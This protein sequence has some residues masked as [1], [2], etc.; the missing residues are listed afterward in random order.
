MSVLQCHQLTKSFDALPVVRGIDLSI[1]QGEFVTLLGPSGCGKT[2][3][4]RLFAGF[5]TPDAGWI[6]VNG[7][8]VAGRG[9]FVQPE[10]RHIGMV[11][12]DYA[13]FPHLNVHENIAFGLKGSKGEKAARV[14]EMLELVGLLGLN[15][16]MTHELSGGQQQRVALAR[17]LAPQPNVLLLDEPFSN[18]D[19]TLRAQVRTE[20]KAILKQ[21]GTACIFVTHD[22]EEALSLSDRIAVMFAGQF[23][24]V[25]TPQTVY[26]QPATREVA[27]FVGEA[28]FV[29]GEALGTIAATALGEV[30]LADTAQ[31]GVD[32]MLRP[33]QLDLSAKGDGARAEV[34][35]QE[36]YGHGQ[37]VG[38]TLP[39]GTPLTVRADA[40]DV[41]TTG[42][43]VGVLIK[44][45]GRTYKPHPPSPSP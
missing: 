23:A 9:E 6:A 40:T 21:A 13:L 2:T 24:Q 8:T 37:R 27:A 41:Y 22:Q 43:Q 30:S 15:K 25:D 35:W 3:T 29:R 26:R 44:G 20:V 17:A 16:R 31:G 36:Y 1:T 10:D 4:L 7:R 42:Q 19:A 14:E 11:F 28:N 5:E 32:V 45:S 18:L 12:Q 39:D 34:R 38:V 33:E